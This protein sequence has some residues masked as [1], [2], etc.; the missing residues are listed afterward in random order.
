MNISREYLNVSRNAYKPCHI[1]QEFINPYLIP[2]LIIGGIIGNIL[3]IV[4]IAGTKLRKHSSNGYLVG[5]FAS[6][7]I[8]LLNH[9]AVKHGLCNGQLLCKTC[10]FTQYLTTFFS[11][12]ILTAFTTERFIVVA[13]PWQQV[14]HIKSWKTT[15]RIIFSILLISVICSSPWLHI[16][17]SE[18]GRCR[19]R[20]ESDLMKLLLT[21]LVYVESVLTLFI[22]TIIICILNF[23][24]AKAITKSKK[25]LTLVCQITYSPYSVTRSEKSSHV[26]V[27]SEKKKEDH[28][29]EKLIILKNVEKGSRIPLVRKDQNSINI[30]LIV[31]SIT[32]LVCNVPFYMVLTIMK[33]IADTNKASAKHNKII[34][35]L[36]YVKSMLEYL[37]LLN[38]S[39]NFLL[40]SISSRHFRHCFMELLISLK[41]K[42]LGLCKK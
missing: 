19:H 23:W 31:L 36:V 7:S 12:W 29:I 30:T 13:Y 14:L 38:F 4:A 11:V 25:R 2:L 41:N 26:E 34:V 32:F 35:K 15:N 10:I 16:V 17:K 24:I 1:C 42:L 37:Y 18:K 20:D 6:D 33:I 5:L 27:L 3:C 8:T 22:P 9:L 28:E 21:T 39:L 40:Y